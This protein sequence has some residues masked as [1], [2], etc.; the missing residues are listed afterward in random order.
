V[1][2]RQNHPSRPLWWNIFIS[3]VF[4]CVAIWLTWP[5]VT[6]LGKAIVGGPIAESDGWQNVWNF[7]WVRTAILHGKNPLYTNLLYWPD[8]VPLGLHTFTLTSAI[9]TLPVLLAVGP[10]AAYGVVALLNFTLSGLVTYRLALSVVEARFAALA[11]GLVVEAAPLHVARYMD[12]QH[13]TSL[14]WIALYLIV[15]LHAT[16]SPTARSGLWL[17][18]SVAIVAYTSWYQAL[19]L[20]VLTAVWLLYHLLEGRQIWPLA[21]PWLV[22]APVLALLLVPV[23]PGLIAGVSGADRTAE[24]WQTQ[25]QFYSAD[26]VD[27]LL[28]SANHPLWGPAVTA[29]QQPLHPNSIGWMI[30]PGY[31]ALALALVG[32]ALYWRAARLWGLLVAVLFVFSLGPTL[33]V[34]G[35]DTGVPLPFAIINALPGANF[36]RRPSLATVVAL[37]PLALLAGFGVRALCERLRGR[38]LV[39]LGVLLG[40]GLFEAAPPAM[41]VFFDT[42]PPI[43]RSLRGGAGALLEVPIYP[44]SGLAN[45]SAALR[46]QMT[47]GRP[48]SAG[49]VARPPDYPLARGAPLIGQINRQGCEPP[50]IVPDDAVI[51]RSA[52]TYYGYTQAVVHADLL[53]SRELACARKLF[54]GTLGLRPSRVAGPVSIYDLMPGT[55]QPF[56]FLGDD[57][58]PLEHDGVRMWRWMSDEGKLYLINTDSGPRTFALHLRAV[59]FDHP[60][61]VE[62]SLDRRSLGTLNIDLAPARTYTLLV[63][64]D[65]G[66]HMLRLAAPA[67]HD[68]SA[69]RYI[70]IL[71]ESITITR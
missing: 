1:A 70:S 40:L 55:L 34:N 46:A 13:H 62:T 19:F 27:L 22:A 7:W 5:Q 16:R 30:A 39:V 29:Y 68:P 69:D 32:L 20:A 25:A 2:D 51:M 60:R 31:V 26:L 54:E 6:V 14:Q 15:L 49:Y 66:Q 71:V 37:V 53:S 36:G 33:R 23:I 42:T 21:R 65:P 35:S 18:L 41:Q 38:R 8:G 44:P 50:G 47:H 57:W 11:A 48:I 3:L 12:G 17:A 52:L 58:L 61:A 4:L 63:R 24:H 56:I 28:P 9:L 45:K 43:Y 59:S 10:V 67:D 64:V